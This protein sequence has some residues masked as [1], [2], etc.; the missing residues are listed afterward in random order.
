M[1]LIECT[2]DGADEHKVCHRRRLVKLPDTNIT[3]AFMR[4]GIMIGISLDNTFIS[5]L[6]QTHKYMTV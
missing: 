4:I 6:K 3:L 2:V 5:Q 1:K